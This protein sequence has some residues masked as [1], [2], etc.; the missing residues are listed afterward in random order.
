MCAQRTQCS[1]NTVLVGSACIVC[2]VWSSVFRVDSVSVPC[3]EMLLCSV[4]SVSVDSASVQSAERKL[5]VC[6]EQVL[7]LLTLRKP[8]VR[9]KHMCV[10]IFIILAIIMMMT[11]RPLEIM[12]IILV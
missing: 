6:G 1:V 7:A 11:S 10:N 8:S 2:H 3:C 9:S 4:D 5:C 12:N